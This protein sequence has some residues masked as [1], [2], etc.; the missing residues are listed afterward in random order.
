MRAAA[1]KKGTIKEFMKKYGDSK[2]KSLAQ[3]GLHNPEV[4]KQ[5]EA[6]R[7]RQERSEQTK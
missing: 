5:E 3:L 2:P 1:I 4:E 6:K 7:R